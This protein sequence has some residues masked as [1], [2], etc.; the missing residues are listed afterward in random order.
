MKAWMAM[1]AAMLVGVG[2]PGFDR[3][4][5]LPVYAAEQVADQAATVL[6]AMRKALGGA[7]LDEVKGLSVEGPFRRQMGQRDMEG[8]IALVLVGPDKMHRLEDLALMGGAS[9]ERIQALS[10]ETSWTDMQNR[11]GMGGGMQIMMRDGPPG[12]PGADPAEMEKRRTTTFKA[13][14]QR[15][16]FALLGTPAGE[17]T[18]AGVAEAPDGRADMIEM[19]DARGQAL[20]LFVD[21]STHLPLMLSYQEIRPRIMMQGG[22]G[23][24]GGRRGGGPGGAGGAPGAGAGGAPG[25]PAGEPGAGAPGAGPGGQRPS[26]EEMQRRMAAMPPPTPSAMTMTFDEYASVDGVKL[27]KRISL[28]ADN[29]PVEEWT[30]EKIKVN[31]SVKA[32]LF[33]KK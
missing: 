1:A 19:K 14:M 25:A 27:P 3:V 15:W 22:P 21:Q 13:E 9:V 4:V 7:K 32:D 2:T 8:T 29:T 26:P 17:V 5:P 6:A 23:G 24:R 16:M 10:G 18:Y 33:E 11:G 31:P 28:S 12:A 30:L 20:R